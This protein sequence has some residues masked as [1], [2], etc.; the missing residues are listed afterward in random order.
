M[1]SVAGKCLKA[2]MALAFATT[3]RGADAKENYHEKS[4]NADTREK[5]EQV[6]ASIRDEMEQGGR[7]EYVKPD[8]RKTVDLKL[9]EIDA[10]FAENGS[11]EN[12]QQDTKIKVYNAQEVV[13]SI[14]TKRDRDRV[15]CKNEAPL[16]SHIPVTTCHTY[17]QEQDARHQTQKQMD[18]WGRP[19][20]VGGGCVNP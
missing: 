1:Q 8:E 11:L 16:G 12:M 10:L 6:A 5:F 9:T 13:N 14:L 7:Y 20:C 3:A 17:G 4:L 19:L 18:D 2:L 15:I